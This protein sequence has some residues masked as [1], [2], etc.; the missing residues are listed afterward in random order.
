[1]NATTP[2][3]PPGGFADV[4]RYRQELTERDVA[5]KVLKAALSDEGSEQRFVAEAN[6]MARLSTHPYIVT[7]HLAGVTGDG[8]PYLVME[9]CSRDDLAQR[10]KRE[11]LS[12]AE[13]LRIG[14]GFCIG[15]SS[16]PTSSQPITATLRSPT[17]VS[18]PPCTRRRGSTDCPFPGR[19]RRQSR[20]RPTRPSPATSTHSP[21]RSGIC[22]WAARRSPCP[23]V[24][25]AAST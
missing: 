18:R 14:P 7:I 21:P 12:I 16:Q 22:S 24:P 1:V 15:T 17:S 3:A 13:V 11:T 10:V 9:Y 25:T 19:R 23:A 4:F 8:R 5:V 6:V 2:A 20:T